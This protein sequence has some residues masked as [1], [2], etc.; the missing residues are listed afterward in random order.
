MPTC[1][2]CGNKLLPRAKFCIY[3]GQKVERLRKA[4]RTSKRPPAK[5]Q[6]PQTL[7]SYSSNWC[8]NC[9]A[10]LLT[11]ARFCLVCGAEVVVSQDT[12]L[13]YLAAFL[14]GIV[15]IIPA[16]LVE[17]LFSLG[18]NSMSALAVAAGFVEEPMKQLGVAR[19]AFRTPSGISSRRDGLIAGALAGAGFGIIESILYVTILSSIIPLPEAIGA[20]TL[21]VLLHAGMSAIAGMGVFYATTRKEN[22]MLKFFLLLLVAIAVHS[23]WD[24][25]ALRMG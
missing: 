5:E 3:C 7:V 17:S 24:Y 20:R 8:Q 13:T 9:G 14:G 15:A 4:Q 18:L 1:P 2:K 23:S 22:G 25:A 16:A 12:R 6:T 11:D 21:T 19:M 10:R